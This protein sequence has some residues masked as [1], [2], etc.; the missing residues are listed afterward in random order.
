MSPTKL[1]PCPSNEYSNCRS[2]LRTPA[3]EVLSRTQTS[4][5]SRQ[6]RSNG[7]PRTRA[8]YDTSASGF[9]EQSQQWRTS[10]AGGVIGSGLGR[11]VDGW[12]YH[13]QDRLD[14]VNTG[15]SHARNSVAIAN[16]R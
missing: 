8:Y 10:D 11:S 1:H 5:P 3:L 7:Q 14:A 9:S 6:Q 15:E 12:L 16:Q 2:W 4:P 13:Q